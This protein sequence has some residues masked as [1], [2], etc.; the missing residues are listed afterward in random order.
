MSE[1]LDDHPEQFS[2]LSS[3]HAA[4]IVKHC[5]DITLQVSE[6]YV[7]EDVH[8]APGVADASF[9]V[10]IGQDLKDIV[11]ADSQSKLGFVVG[12]NCAS[13]DSEGRWHEMNF[14]APHGDPI[15]LQV[16]FFRLVVDDRQAHLLCA[17]DL[18]PLGKAQARFQREL[19]DYVRRT[20]S[21]DPAED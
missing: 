13:D 21:D 10:W 9:G 20:A 1:G 19:T 14:N 16:K 8:V 18:R 6:T 7:V 15:P 2:G 4:L 11:C 17:R 5:S 12:D 3:V